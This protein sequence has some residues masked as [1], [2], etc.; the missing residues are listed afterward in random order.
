MFGRKWQL[1]TQ[2]MGMMTFAF[3][4][5][6]GLIALIENGV[7][8][9]AQEPEVTEEVKAPSLES[10]AASVPQIMNYQGYAKDP[11]GNPLNGSHTMTFRIYPDVVGGSALWEEQLQNVTV[12]AGDFSVLLGDSTPLPETLFDEP[13]RF[14]GVTIDAN[15]EMVPRQRFASVP[16]AMEAHHAADADHAD[17]ATHASVASDADTVDGMHATTLVPPGTVVAYAG[18]TPPS[19]WLQCDGLAVSRSEYAELFAAIGTTWGAGNGSTTF[20]LPDFRGRG[21]IGAGQ[22]S[23]LTNRVLGQRSGAETHTLTIAEIPSHSHSVHGTDHNN[24]PRHTDYSSGEYGN[25]INNHTN[26]GSTGSNQP[27]NNM[28]PFAVVNFIIKH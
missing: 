12:R 7:A 27:H 4:A 23:G 6:Y 2:V 10:S 11:E 16:F 14:I 21:P 20:N 5:V 13:D 22:G 9:W 24:T 8:V 19:G 1:V 26:T 28:P 18:S 17:E 3:L 25:Y 15:H